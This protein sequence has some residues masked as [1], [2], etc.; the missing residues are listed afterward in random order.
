MKEAYRVLKPGGTFIGIVAF[1]EPFHQDSFYHHTHLGTYNSLREGGFTVQEICPSKE[2]SVLK[3]QAVMGYS[4]G[5]RRPLRLQL[6][7]R[8]ICCIGCGGP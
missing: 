2:W 6:S 1:S 7:R 4:P 8:L 5:C 3:A